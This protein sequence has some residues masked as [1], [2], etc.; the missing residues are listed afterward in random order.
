MQRYQFAEE[1]IGILQAVSCEA[2]LSNQT[3][4]RIRELCNHIEIVELDDINPASKPAMGD[5]ISQQYNRA[6]PLEEHLRL[7]IDELAQEKNFIV[8]QRDEFQRQLEKANERNE[9]YKA[10]I[11][12]LSQTFGLQQA[13]IE[14]YKKK[15]K[16]IPTICFQKS[17]PYERDLVSIDGPL[18]W[19]DK[20]TLHIP[21]R[22]ERLNVAPASIPVQGEK[23]FTD[24][25][26]RLTKELEAKTDQC[27]ALER[28]YHNVCVSR[29]NAQNRANIAETRLEKVRKLIGS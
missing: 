9:L 12:N 13:V 18:H 8:S 26:E 21:V 14:E 25:I 27:A 6:M 11:D 23:S 19:D 15:E 2:I 24:E 28:A 4:A 22:I 29:D 10:Q 17:N 20:G 3:K 16:T 1:L 7:R 5:P